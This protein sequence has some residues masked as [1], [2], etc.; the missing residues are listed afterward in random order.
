MPERIFVSV[1][2]SKPNDLIELPGAITAAQRMASWA[3]ANGYRS[4]TIDDRVKPVTVD[5][6]RKELT[7][8]LT[9]ATSRLIFFF[10]GHGSAKDAN[11]SYW[12]LSNWS[13]NWSEAIDVSAFQ[14]MLRFFGPKQV[15]VIGDCCRVVH[16]SFLDV[17]G[18]A[19]L[20]RPDNEPS[21][22]EL[23]RF[24][25][26]DAGEESFMIRAQGSNDAFCI[27]TEVLLDALEGDAP[28]AF[29]LNVDGE[30]TVTSG[31]LTVHLKQAVPV[32]ATRYK[33][34]MK[35]IPEPGYY[36]DRVYARFPPA[37]PQAPAAIPP[38]GRVVLDWLT[39][40][41]GANETPRSVPKADLVPAASSTGPSEEDRIQ[42]E[43]GRR[44]EEAAKFLADF[45]PANVPTHFETNCGLAV[46]GAEARS[47]E[48]SVGSVER[49]PNRP[50]IWFPIY[51]G[52]EF[53][54]DWSNL[55]VEF[56]SGQR[57]YV[58]AI[59]GF[60]TT[61]QVHNESRA[62]VMY[63]PAGLLA[64]VM[65]HAA[66]D[67][68]ARAN[69]SL[70]SS[71][72]IVNTAAELRQSKHR[73]FTLGCIAAYLYDSIGDVESI[74]SIAAFYAEAG[75]AVP[76]DIGLLCGGR[77]SS[78]GGKL[79]LDIPPTPSRQP[80]TDMEEQRRFTHEATAGFEHAPVGGS[81][82]WMRSG[83]TAV[84]TAVLAES[85]L[86]WRDRALE[87]IP[88]LTPSPFTIVREEGREALANL[89]GVRVPQLLEV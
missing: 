82:P 8:L 49:D 86:G 66:I 9:P 58:C 64:P 28:D 32:E 79:V 57:A 6:I 41:A 34:A 75:Q 31:S 7:P 4:L 70:L 15:T 16:K 26:A 68:L 50:D 42:Q 72:D 61:L 27:F 21:E 23:D 11:K 56:G 88:H 89:V 63:G 78:D 81:A 43:N 24:F 83:W 47:V 67:V 25:A 14:R 69:A 76:L 62:S 3:D 18:S 73:D 52:G 74:R 55:V 17:L 19:V 65:S 2:V 84:S 51:I 36:T 33:V 40:S 85:A 5:R 22:F 80:R 38:V 44:N 35:P 20:D 46:L 12:L 37:R 1:A 77:L 39:L 59:Q 10:A 48:S 45:D 54:K 87:V 30:R 29:E 53:G 13:T 60:I 71:D